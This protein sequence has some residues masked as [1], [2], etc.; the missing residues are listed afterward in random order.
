MSRQIIN[1]SRIELTQNQ[2]RS[3]T[4][5]GKLL[6]TNLE[7]K[8]AALFISENR[9]KAVRIYPDESN[10]M[11]GIYIGKV[12]NIVK[13]LNACF[14]EIGGTG[15]E[16]CFLSQKDSTFPYL[17][18][19]TYDGRIL[20][21]DEFPVQIIRNAQKTKQASV[22]T[23]LSVSNEFFALSIGNP[24]TGY[25]NKLSPAQKERLKNLLK[26]VFANFRDSYH[27]S[28]PLEIPANQYSCA[29]P[30][31]LIVRTKASQWACAEDDRE[32]VLQIESNLL[33]LKDCLYGLYKDACHRTCFTC[34]KEPEPFWKDALSSLVRPCEYNEILTDDESIY[35]ELMSPRTCPSDQVKIRLYTAEER[36]AL[37]LSKLYGLKGKM[38]T[39]LERRVWL[40]SG[41]YLIIDI[42]EAMTVIDVNSG[43]Y[44]VSKTSEEGYRI[45]N[46]EA[47]AEIALQL[48]LRNLSGIILIDFINMKGTSDQEELLRYL[49]ELTKQDTEK[50]NVLDITAL[51]LVEVTRKKTYATL[52]EQVQG[53]EV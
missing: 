12:K 42:T 33:E 26:K 36:E 34:L 7:G 49:K 6:L 32:A 23:H 18:N 53:R 48:R 29:L 10:R 41:G 35:K 43:K 38:D 3:S 2:Y 40:K 27:F 30:V 15:K 17:L 50:V 22:T 39:A 51:G 44:D 47:A 11:G 19:R 45:L 24:K 9:L 5:D 20:E 1:P 37:P 25:S 31:G 46:R 21:G 52:A 8:K 13:N 28:F 16:I 4:P 14:V